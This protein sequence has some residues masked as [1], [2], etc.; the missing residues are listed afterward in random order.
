VGDPPHAASTSQAIIAK[1]L[2]ERPA[3]AR[4]AR[5]SIPLHVDAA[6]ARSLEKLPA[7]RFSTAREFAEA[8]GGK[9]ASSG[10]AM[11]EMS[12]TPQTSGLAKR[13]KPIRELAAWVFVAAL[14]GWLG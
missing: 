5:P 9:G 6:I 10:P 1:V 14:A 3:S 2:T 7:D 13:A 11:S 8:V 4:A 12:A